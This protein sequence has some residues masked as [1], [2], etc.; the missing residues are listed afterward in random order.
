VTISCRTLILLAVAATTLALSGAPALAGGWLPA[1]S[2][3]TIG[4]PELPQGPVSD[5]IDQARVE[6]VGWTTAT[7]SA[8]LSIRRPGG[9]L[10]EQT[11]ELSN[12]GASALGY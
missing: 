11:I 3:A 2:A 4:E 6:A 9:T 12:S 1:Q 10:V 5:A 7:G 8:I